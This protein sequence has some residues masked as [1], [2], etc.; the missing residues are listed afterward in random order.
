MSL[1]SEWNSFKWDSFPLNPRSSQHG[2]GWAHGANNGSSATGWR[3]RLKTK[4]QRGHKQH[5]D[6]SASGGLNARYW[7][8]S[9]RSTDDNFISLRPNVH[10][11]LMP[12]L[13]PKRKQEM[14]LYH[15][16]TGRQSNKRSNSRHDFLRRANCFILRLLAVMRRPVSPERGGRLTNLYRIWRHRIGPILVERM[17]AGFICNQRWNRFWPIDGSVVHPESQT[18]RQTDSARRAE[19]KPHLDQVI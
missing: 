5:P 18:S 12:Q 15:N 2:D 13:R 16:Y 11:P 10:L 19:L 1:W 3:A 9:E 6:T 7:S 8:A 17:A 4:K 14:K